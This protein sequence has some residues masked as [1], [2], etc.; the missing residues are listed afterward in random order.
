MGG[1]IF[2]MTYRREAKEIQ[3]INNRNSGVIERSSLEQLMNFM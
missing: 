1:L 2:V 3:L